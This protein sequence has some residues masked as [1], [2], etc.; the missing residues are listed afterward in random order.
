MTTL[1]T[2]IESAIL[3]DERKIDFIQEKEESMYLGP[4]NCYGNGRTDWD[5]LLDFY[6]FCEENN[7]SMNLNYSAWA[8]FSEERIKKG[9]WKFPC[10]SYLNCPDGG[11]RKP[12]GWYVVGCG[13]GYYG[14]NDKI[15]K[16]M[17]AYMDE[18]NLEVCGPA[19]ETYPLNEISVNDPENYLIR[20]SITARRKN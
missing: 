17:V 8:M 19:Y 12:A 18:H 10:R 7:R 14:Q 20:I 15:Y 6:R 13:R 16:K 3:V 5:A 9:D 11:D 2:T 4:Q 1:H